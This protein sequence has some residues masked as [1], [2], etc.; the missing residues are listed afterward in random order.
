MMPDNAIIVSFMLNPKLP[1]PGI[2]SKKSAP[3]L[4]LLAFDLRK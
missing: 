1:W 3:L 2:Y 4:Y